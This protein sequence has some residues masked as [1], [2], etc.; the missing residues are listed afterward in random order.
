[1]EWS[2]AEIDRLLELVNQKT[3]RELAEIFDCTVDSIRFQCKKLNIKKENPYDTRSQSERD[4]IFGSYEKIGLSLTASKYNLTLD[5]VKAI[6]ARQKKRQKKLVSQF[7]VEDAEKFRGQAL[8]VGF[9]RLPNGFA[10]DFASYCM[11][12]A[13]QGKISALKWMLI[14]Y[15]RKTFGD[16]GS[17]K[18]T[19]KISGEDSFQI[20]DDLNG[21]EDK[22]NHLYE[23]VD[24]VRLSGDQRFCFLLSTV[25]GLNNREISVCLNVTATHVGNLL[26]RAAEAIR[27]QNK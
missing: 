5:T 25:F 16:L 3:Y 13:Y 8:A 9:K 4:R 22:K 21:E 6:A 27:K 1:M 14:D 2:T 18:G 7:T 24:A 17:E 12:R 19:A 11:V 20:I 10:E 15:K 26:E 23:L